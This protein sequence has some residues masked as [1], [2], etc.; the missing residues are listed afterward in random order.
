MDTE[1]KGGAVFEIRVRIGAS[2]EV[3][4][5][6]TVL[7]RDKEHAGE[8]GNA[9]EQKILSAIKDS[10]PGITLEASAFLQLVKS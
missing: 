2:I 3:D 9:L 8:L 10:H 6:T 1:Q 5:T 7:A 4:Y